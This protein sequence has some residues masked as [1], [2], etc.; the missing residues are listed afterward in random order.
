MEERRVFRESNRT[1]KM[2]MRQ[3]KSLWGI[4]YFLV[5]LKHI[6]SWGWGC[7]VL[8]S[9]LQSQVGHLTKDRFLRK[10]FK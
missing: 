4:V 3:Q 2:C 5:V 8:F 6:V 1:K 10:L 9:P 7:P